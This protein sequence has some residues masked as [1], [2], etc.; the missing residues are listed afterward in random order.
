MGKYEELKPDNLN[1]YSINER[2]S[3]VHVRDFS[4]PLG[5]WPQ[6]A[7]FIDSLPKILKAQDLVQLINNL[8]RARDEGKTILWLLL[9]QL[10]AG[11]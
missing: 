7:E 8:V 9:H 10:K 1:R 5:E 2:K 4:K 6:F 3:K 11:S